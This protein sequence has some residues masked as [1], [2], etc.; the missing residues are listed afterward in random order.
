MR[1]S[2]L[3]Q[4]Y[5]LHK[6]LAW[7]LFNLTIFVYI[8]SKRLWTYTTRIFMSEDSYCTFLTDTRH[9]QGSSTPVPALAL[10]LQGKENLF[11][12]RT[13][14]ACTGSLYEEITKT[15]FSTKQAQ[16]SCAWCL[17]FVDSSQFHRFYVG[18]N[19]H[20]SVQLKRFSLYTHIHYMYIIIYIITH[21]QLFASVM[22]HMRK[23]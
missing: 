20:V 22:L 14:L 11:F 19:F 23:N 12:H 9:T 4:P 1:Q 6:S 17:Q 2:S 5:F 16:I 21:N 8:Q 10:I 7:S 3:L 15:S 18:T 13:Q